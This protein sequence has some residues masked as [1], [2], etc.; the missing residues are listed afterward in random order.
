MT[1]RGAP[2]RL[3]ALVVFLTAALGATAADAQAPSTLGVRP[4]SLADAVATALRQNPDS[5]TSESVVHGAEADRA[6]VAGGYGPKLHVD[7]NATQWNSPFDINFGGLAF[8]VR[9]A[10][11]WSAS[12]TVTQPLTPLWSIYD[13]Y[14]V[15]DLGVDVAGIRR[16]VTRREVAFQ[17]A[18]AYYRLLEADRLAEVARTSVTQLEAQQREAQSLFDNGVI[19]KNDLLRAGLALASSK[20]REI[21]MR[22]NVVL[23]RGQL[24]TL[25]GE[26]G[27]DL[28]A[29]PFTGEPGGV[30]EP[31]VASA[32][33]RA[34]AQR[35]EVRELDR[36]IEQADHGVA[37]AKKKL[38]PQVNAVGN[39]THFEG[40]QFQQEDAAFVGLF[41]SWDVWDWG[42]T[43]SGIS[44]ANAR[45]DQARIAR[46]KIEDQVRLE[47]R[48]AF[49]NAETAREAL[50]VART[51]VSQAEE[52]FRIVTKK[53]EAAAATS[54]DVVD[55]ESLLTQ[56]RGQVETGL[57]DLLIA[58]A[59][60]ARATGTALP[61]EK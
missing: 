8:Q 4:V 36:S 38:I 54:F 58:R 55:A 40:S 5:L 61:G 47:A 45:L 35:L 60:L 52:N 25:M 31:S 50:A 1:S 48:Q 57:Y 26:P 15:Q 46:K 27:A 17:V 56:A 21:Q 10:F 32:E 14:R 19:G 49:V 59:A 7:A 13:Q 9:N 6:V 16:Q 11:T 42:T 22:G 37:T 24:A 44:A 29:E 20:Q 43:T 18:Q 39:Y 23:A 33:T 28:H 41:A 53:F 51:A 2:R 3:A 12:V 30:D 34:A